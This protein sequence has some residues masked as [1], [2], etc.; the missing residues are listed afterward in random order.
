MNSPFAADLKNQQ[1]I[2]QACAST[3]EGRHLPAPP[4]TAMRS[5]ARL[6]DQ[7]EGRLS[8]PAH[9]TETRRSQHLLKLPGAG[10]SA[11]N[12]GALLRDSVGTAQGGRGGIVEPAD[13]IDVVLDPIAREGL[14]QHEGAVSGHSVCGV[15]RGID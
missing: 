4:T 15:P 10:L 1:C 2:R 3:D 8:S 12:M 5:K 7:V 13:R 11:E 9:G 14:D 6:N